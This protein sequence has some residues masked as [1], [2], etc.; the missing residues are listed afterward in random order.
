MA[1]P[2]L[3][4]PASPWPAAP[5]LLMDSDASLILVPHLRLEKTPLSFPIGLARGL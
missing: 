2:W 5:D 1:I 3:H 4:A